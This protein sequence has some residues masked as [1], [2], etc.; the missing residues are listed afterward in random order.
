MTSQQV[1]HRAA[2]NLG[3]VCCESGSGKARSGGYDVPHKG[4]AAAGHMTETGSRVGHSEKVRRGDTENL[5]A[6]NI[7]YLRRGFCV[8]P[9]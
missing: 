3:G 1:I 6:D 9:V 7:Y 5:R 8:A 2:S 4:G